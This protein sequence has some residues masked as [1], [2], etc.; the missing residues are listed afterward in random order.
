MAR[1]QLR[2]AQR[3]AIHARRSVHIP[4]RTQGD[5]RLGLARAPRRAAGALP[6]RALRAASA[7]AGDDGRREGVREA[8]RRPLL[9]RA[10]VQAVLPRRQVGSGHRLDR[11]PA[12]LR[13][14]QGA[15]VRPPELQRQRLHS[16]RQ[17]QPLH[18]AARADRRARLRLHVR[19]LHPDLCRPD[20]EGGM[21]RYGLRRRVRAVG[22]ATRRRPTTPASSWRGHGGSCADS[23]SRRGFPRSTRRGAW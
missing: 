22:R 4:R 18:P 9:G 12:A 13:E 1:L 3:P 6:D 16:D 15:G 20:Q 14:G 7:A 8:H 11:V 5:D 17:D 10:Q 21:G 19:P 2:R 23:T